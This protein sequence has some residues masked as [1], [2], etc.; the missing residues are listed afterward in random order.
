MTNILIIGANGQIARVATR[1]LLERTDATLTLYL[2][3]ARRL[4]SLASNPRIRLVE[5]DATDAATLDQ[6]MVGQDIVYANLAGDMKR[7][8]QTIVA[9]MKKASVRRLIFISSMGIYGEVPGQRYGSILD[10]YRDSAAVVENSGLDFTVIRPAWLN[11][12][13]EIAYG[14]TQKGE[15]FANATATVSRASIA[16]LIVRLVTLPRF[17]IGD[18]FGVHGDRDR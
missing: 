10:P 7:Q 2:R 8:A 18:S 11:D 12:E 16:D 3:H 4:G 6:A 14:I 17:G 15:P 5:G 9:S 13:D 1:Q